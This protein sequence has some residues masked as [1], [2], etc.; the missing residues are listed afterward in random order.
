MHTHI[1]TSLQVPGETGH[2]WEP[3]VSSWHPQSPETHVHHKM[4]RLF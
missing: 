3:Q 1:H 2:L 4:P